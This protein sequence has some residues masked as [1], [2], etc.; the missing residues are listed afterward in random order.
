[1]LPECDFI[2]DDIISSS[3]LCS[4]PFTP[5]DIFHF[6]HHNYVVIIYFNQPSFC[7]FT[8]NKFVERPTS[9][10]VQLLLQLHLCKLYNLRT[11]TFWKFGHSTVMDSMRSLNSSLP[12]SSSTKRSNP[13]P[14]QLIQSFKTAALSVTNLYKT[15][16]ADQARARDAGYQ[17]ALDDLLVFLDK[18]NLGLDD[19][20]GWKVRQWATERLDGS[21]LAHTGSDSEDERVETTK[22]AR[23]SSPTVQR[24]TALEAENLR[25]PSRSTSPVRT[26]STSMPPPPAATQTSS[27]IQAPQPF[28]FRSAIPY[29]QDVD[30]QISE[31][32][33]NNTSPSAQEP[34]SQT[35]IPSSGPAV[36][37]EVVPRGSRT[38][39]RGTRHTTRPAAGTRSL[40]AGAGSKRRITFGDY[41]DLGNLGDGKDGMGGGGKRSRFT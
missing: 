36:R 39:H 20:E 35:Q 31:S 32:T 14:E 23:S 5:T 21:P 18:E 24:S 1:M 17:H 9:A 22:R 19:G 27:P 10:R 8:T 26:T 2:V 16:A 37:L 29:P 41:F 12:R 6:R 38:P 7:L 33:S 25:Q 28:L 40:G 4:T 11:N 13:P 30:M 3:L 15:A 34:Q